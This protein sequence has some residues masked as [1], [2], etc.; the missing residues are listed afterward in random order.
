MKK[1][2]IK[3]VARTAGVSISTVS[4]ALSGGGSLKPE[5]R[6]R[7][8]EIA[9][10]M[11]YM[12]DLYGSNLRAKETNIIGLFVASMAGS[13]YGVLADTLYNSCKKKGYDL[14]IYITDYSSQVTKKIMSK[15]I[16]GAV[17]L[18]SGLTYDDVNILKKIEIPVVFLD[19]EISHKYIGS[20]VFDSYGA[21]RQIGEYFIRMGFKNMAFIQGAMG[22]YDSLERYKGY[23]DALA[24]AGLQLKN[25]NILYGAFEKTTSYYAMKGF[26]ESGNELPDA[27]FAA[28]DLSAIGCIEA[29][30]EAGIK[31]P[32]DVSVVGCDDIDISEWYRPALTTIKTHFEK[33]GELAAKQLLS[34]IQEGSDGTVEKIHGE[35]VERDS[36]IRRNAKS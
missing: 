27:I 16:D 4:H 23:R 13:Y 29:L 19:R 17:I 35:L 28:N 6:Q 30:S 5:T 24:E 2:T 3:D 33:H 9:T 18:H 36:C 1:V 21:G 26:I 31:V 34:M 7:V 32:Q 12:P 15:R 22:T 25:T 8:I 14:D 11:H 20:V 10:Q